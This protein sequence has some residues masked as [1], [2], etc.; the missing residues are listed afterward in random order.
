MLTMGELVLGGATL[1]F[2]FAPTNMLWLVFVARALQ[3]CAAAF[4]GTLPFNTVSCS[5]IKQL[6]IKVSCLI[7]YRY[8]CHY[9][10]NQE[11]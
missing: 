8:C 3:G 7:N 9:Y 10:S 11:L 4:S 1:L 6:V 5:V 2:G